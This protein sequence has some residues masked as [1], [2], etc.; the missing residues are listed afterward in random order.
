MVLEKKERIEKL[1][2]GGGGEREGDERGDKG[3]TMIS[4]NVGIRKKGRERKGHEEEEEEEE[5]GQ[6]EE[7]EEER[8]R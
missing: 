8:V 2:G 7:E 5:E 1:A 6:E 3:I 4:K